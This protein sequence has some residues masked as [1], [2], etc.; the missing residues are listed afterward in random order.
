M[1]SIDAMRRVFRHAPLTEL[2]PNPLKQFGHWFDE[3]KDSAPVDWLEV[4]AMT[5]CTQGLD[6]F[7]QSRI[8]LLKGISEQGLQ[9]F[10]NYQSH[11]GLELAA[12]PRASLN[13]YWPHLARQVRVQGLV[14]KL[15]RS[16]SEAYFASRPRGSQL[17]AWASHQSEPISDASVLERQLAEAEARF[18]DT[19]P[20]P[21]HW[22]GYVLVPSLMEFWAGRENRLHH[23]VRYQRTD[24]KWQLQW[25]QP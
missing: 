12:D 21:P 22:G 2:D 6:G 25:L 24:N 5:L 9:F 8:V 3:A 1:M 7:P 13:F 19:V 15:P 23:R 18:G 16:D 17:G 4:N 14:T 11:K 20:C 10:T